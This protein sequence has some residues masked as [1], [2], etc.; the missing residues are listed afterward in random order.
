MDQKSVEIAS[1]LP[2]LHRQGDLT[3]G[4]AWDA[5][6]PQVLPWQN[7]R[8]VVSTMGKGAGTDKR[9]ETA[10]T[11][12]VGQCD[13]ILL[14]PEASPAPYLAAL[15]RAG[16]LQ[17]STRESRLWAPLARRL[18]KDVGNVRP[19]RVV[20]TGGTLYGVMASPAAITRTV[21]PVP[22]STQY[23]TDTYL[24]CLFVFDRSEVSLLTRGA[25]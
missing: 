16:V 4:V 3:V 22:K 25:A 24:P 17:A 9:V 12:P 6:I 19:W 10:T 15:N 5:A 21:R 1:L 20:T 13:V 7:V 18:Q 11:L 2:L 23:L 8:R 14:P